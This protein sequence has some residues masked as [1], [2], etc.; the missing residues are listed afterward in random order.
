MHYFGT[1]LDS[2]GHYFWILD[3]NRMSKS[4]IWFSKIPFNPEELTNDEKG[5]SL[6]K[7][8]IRFYNFEEYTV[9]AI[10]GSCIDKRHGC[11]S[12]FWVQE[13]LTYEEMKKRIFDIPIAKKIIDTM[14][15]EVLWEN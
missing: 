4:D 6:P 8:P 11:K 15:F 14:P 7:G 3:N 10:S 13:K 2:A 9:L 5:N 12:V 1:D